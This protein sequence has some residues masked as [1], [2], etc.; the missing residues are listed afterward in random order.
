MPGR[1][2]N[3]AAISAEA[4]DP[5]F[6]DFSAGN[7]SPDNGAKARSLMLDWVMTLPFNMISSIPVLAVP[8]GTGDAGVPTGIQ[9]AGRPWQD[10]NV[11]DAGHGIEKAVG[12]WPLPELVSQQDSGQP[13]AP[14]RVLHDEDSA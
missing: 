4:E 5:P 3:L 9:I 7:A 14:W 2:P 10:Q 6:G 12:G 11:F 13:T 8:S 1:L